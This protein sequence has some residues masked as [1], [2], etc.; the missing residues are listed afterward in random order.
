M[1]VYQHKTF[2]KRGDRT[3]DKNRCVWC[4]VNNPEYVRYHD[5]EWGSP[6]DD[7]RRLYETFILESFQAGLSWECVLGKRHSFREAYD[8][9]DIDK[10]CVYGEDKIEE[11]M[12]NKSIIRNRLKIRASISNSRIYKSIVNEYG[13][14]LAYLKAFAKDGIIYETGKVSSE[15][16]DLVSKDLK[17]RGM[18]FMGTVTVYSYLQ[19]VGIIYSHEKGCFLYREE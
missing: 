7:E 17:S 12:Q 11:L 1:V 15:L 19:A 3:E 9:F 5:C 16:S 14:F 2:Y 8:G 13:S 6:V 4:N 18:K 10:V